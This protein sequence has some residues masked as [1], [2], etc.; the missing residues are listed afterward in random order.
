MSD[1]KKRRIIGGKYLS[2]LFIFSNV[3]FIGSAYSAKGSFGAK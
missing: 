1:I 2:S 3:R